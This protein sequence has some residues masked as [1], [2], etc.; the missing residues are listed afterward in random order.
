MHG[1]SLKIFA[2]IF[3]LKNIVFGAYVR[4]GVFLGAPRHSVPNELGIG[5]PGSGSPVLTIPTEHKDETMLELCA[6]RDITTSFPD[7]TI[8]IAHRVFTKIWNC[9]SVGASLYCRN[10]TIRAQ[11]MPLILGAPP[12]STRKSLTI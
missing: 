6:G 9:V 2:R 1:I 10:R 3:L 8:P 5:M 7:L 12:Y 4:L 11:K